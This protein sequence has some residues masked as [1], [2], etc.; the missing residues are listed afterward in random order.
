MAASK[1]PKGRMIKEGKVIELQDSEYESQS[2]LRHIVSPMLTPSFR[3][4]PSCRAA[5]RL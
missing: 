3:G 5:K 4:T 1:M 2:V